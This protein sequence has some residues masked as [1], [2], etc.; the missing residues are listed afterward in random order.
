NNNPL[1]SYTSFPVG[2][3]N[4]E[5]NNLVLKENNEISLLLQTEEKFVS[6]EINL[7]EFTALKKHRQHFENYAD[8]QLQSIKGFYAGVGGAVHLN[9]Y[10]LRKNALSSQVGREINYEQS[11]A[12][13]FSVSGGYNFSTHFGIQT[14][15]S[16]LRI[17]QTYSDHSYKKLPI[18]A[19]MQFTF[20]QIPVLAKYK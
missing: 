6:G 16:L 14:E 15:F 8:K 18:D 3:A 12:H 19:D 5:N 9:R 1:L 2:I 4:S 13:S 7:D 17:N 10:L 20:L 11:F